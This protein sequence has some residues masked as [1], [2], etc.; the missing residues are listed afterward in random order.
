KRIGRRVDSSPFAFNGNDD[1][2]TQ[3]NVA[4]FAEEDVLFNKYFRLIGALRADYF[5]FNVSD[6]NEALG[7]GSP[8]T[9]GTAQRALLSP[10]ATAA[11]TP[12]HDLLDLYLNFGMGFHSNMAQIAL[13]DGRT[14]PDGNGGT[15]TVHAVPRIYGGEVGAR[16]HL[17]NRVDVAGAF[18]L[19]YLEN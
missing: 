13:L 3:I 2:I 18:W 14:L 7:A 5:G 10:K 12:I 6:G 1:D 19:S 9:S 8:N 11:I 16:L 15:F 4:A 17:W